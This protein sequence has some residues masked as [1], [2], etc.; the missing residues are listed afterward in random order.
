MKKKFRLW[1]SSR[2]TGCSWTSPSNQKTTDKKCTSPGAC[3]SL[4]GAA[5]PAYKVLQPTAKTL[6]EKCAWSSIKGHTCANQSWGLYKS[7]SVY[8]QLYFF[9]FIGSFLLCTYTG[10]F[11]YYPLLAFSHALF[12]ICLINHFSVYLNFLPRKPTASSQSSCSL[13]SE[14]RPNSGVTPV[15]EGVGGGSL[16]VLYKELRVKNRVFYLP[17]PPSLLMH[18]IHW[19]SMKGPED[20]QGQFSSV[21]ITNMCQC[22]LK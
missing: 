15:L 16:L 7:G 9:Q 13:S 8:L 2:K 4:S 12:I 14:M 19:D 17:H 18:Y 6:W 5:S 3:I 21:D 22:T 10:K 11:S 1:R 20:T